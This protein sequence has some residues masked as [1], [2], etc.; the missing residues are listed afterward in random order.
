MNKL[1]KFASASLLGCGLFVASLCAGQWTLEFDSRYDGD[2]KEAS[3]Y[4]PS[5][6][7][8][9]L[10]TDIRYTYYPGGF[11]SLEAAVY[12]GQYVISELRNNAGTVIREEV[13][14]PLAGNY[15][16]SLSGGGADGSYA[17]ARVDIVW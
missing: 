10:V 13:G 3:I 14:T 12:A 4:V 15:H 16:V 2:H 1:I 9:S 5:A 6:C 8:V 11:A 7:T 17:Y